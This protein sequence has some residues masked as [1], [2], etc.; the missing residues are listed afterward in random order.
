VHAPFDFLRMLSY[1][2]PADGE[3]LEIIDSL[4][5][6]QRV[7]IVDYGCGLAQRSIALAGALKVRQRDVHVTFVDIRRPL[8]VDFLKFLCERRGLASRFVEVDADTPFPSLPPHDFCD[9]V[10]V[11]EHLPEP[12]RAL[13]NIDRSLRH[14]GLLLAAVDDQEAELMHVSPNLRDVRER[15]VELNY[16]RRREMLGATLFEKRPRG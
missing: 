7:D 12:G 5:A 11:L 1:R 16:S 14:G 10:N 9:L 3:M 15:L 8:F 4:A 13:E 6:R 2:I